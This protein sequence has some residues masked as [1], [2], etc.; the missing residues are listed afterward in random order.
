MKV[1][2]QFKDPDTLYE[3]VKDAVKYWI[4][5]LKKQVPSL[6]DE[7]LEAVSKA[8]YEVISDKVGKWFKYGE[9]LTVE[10]DTEADTCTV[11]KP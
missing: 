5:D 3:S 11:V 6:S 1:I 10:V 4:A 2:V 7:E 8:R 9:Y